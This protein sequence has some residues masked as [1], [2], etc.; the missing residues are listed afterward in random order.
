MRRIQEGLEFGIGDIVPVD[1][2]AVDRNFVLMEAPG[3]ILPR[4]GDI[5]SGGIAAFDFDALHRE[6]EIARGNLDHVPGRG[7]D[8]LALRNANHPLW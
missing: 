6:V 3:G 8:G 7:F 4:I 1:I 2:E 5:D